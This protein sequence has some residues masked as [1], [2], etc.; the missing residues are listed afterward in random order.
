MSGKYY[1]GYVLINNGC[2]CN[3]HSKRVEQ[4]FAVAVLSVNVWTIT[5]A[6]ATLSVNVLTA[7]NGCS[8]NA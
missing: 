8:C 5:V 1:N 7:I 4:N 3:V 6:A 2:I